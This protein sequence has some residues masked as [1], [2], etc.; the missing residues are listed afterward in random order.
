LA[1]MPGAV[2][3][4]ARSFLAPVAMVLGALAS[5]M[6]MG[7]LALS[8]VFHDLPI[9][10]LAMSTA[11]AGYSLLFLSA[12]EVINAAAPA[13]HRGGVLSAVYSLAYLSISPVALVLGVVATA[14][15]LRLAVELG[16]GA[17]AVR[18]S[19]LSFSPS[20]CAASPLAPFPGHPRAPLATREFHRCPSR[21]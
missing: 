1:I 3:I 20:R 16:A 9:F 7:L 5:A 6:G 19:P 2:G 15:G 10:L 4:L 8:V 18:A 17:T 12:I 14:R 11:G 13:D 21:Q